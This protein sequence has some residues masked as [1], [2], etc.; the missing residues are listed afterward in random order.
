MSKISD[1]KSFEILDSRGNPTVRTEVWLDDGKMADAAIPSG[2]STGSH[3]AEELRDGDVK[4]FHGMG[5][6]KAI[7]NIH[8]II[9]PA[10]F[11]KDV[12]NQKEIDAVMT[13]LDGTENKSKLGANTILSVSLAVARAAAYS[14]KKHLFQYIRSDLFAKPQQEGLQPANHVVPMFNL[15][16]G[17]LH[18]GNKLT[19]QEFMVVPSAKY[20][21]FESLRIGS[22]IYHS[23]KK[24]VKDTG[25]STGVGD[26]GGF[27]PAFNTNEVA[28]DYLVE[29]IEASHFKVNEDVA[30]S[31]DMAASEYYANGSYN[32][33]VKPIEKSEYIFRLLELNNKYNFLSLEDPL[34]EDDWDAWASLTKTLPPTT[35]IVGDDLLSTNPK[36]LEKAVRMKACNGII[37]KVNQIGTLTET[38]DVISQAKSAGFKILIS[39]RSGETT[40]TFISDLAVATDADYAKFGAPARGERVVKYNRLN[41][42]YEQMK[43]KK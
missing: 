32:Y 6:L 16:N 19:V 9:K 41:W 10:L 33:F 40:D 43:N 14:Q 39:H 35:L 22:E 34:S 24:I 36:R 3:E 27:T 38:L 26:E 12:T 8:S 42:I 31:L 7:E 20:S 29:A 25:L 13:G 5:V 18:G 21:F 17:G 2:A 23:L 37:I 4:R 28:I 11:R 1:I 15:V 30:I